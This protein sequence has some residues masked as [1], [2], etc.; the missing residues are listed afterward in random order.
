MQNKLDE[1]E[2]NI[3]I[4][5]NTVTS[6]T[7]E[8]EQQMQDLS[9]SVD[10]K[11]EEVSSEVDSKLANLW[12]SYTNFS[13]VCNYSETSGREIQRTYTTTSEGWYLFTGKAKSGIQSNE[14]FIGIVAVMIGRT[15]YILGGTC[16]LG[17]NMGEVLHLPS[18]LELTFSI[19]NGSVT[20]Y[21]MS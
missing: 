10:T 13:Q 5:N 9:S 7:E 11:M 2:G 4:I 19:M 18:G 16:F 21:S 8:I 15:E 6:N 14:F 1:M 17:D 3:T 12:P 20:L